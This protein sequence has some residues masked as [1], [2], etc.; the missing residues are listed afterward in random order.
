MGNTLR[1]LK[2]PFKHVYYWCVCK[3]INYKWKTKKY[4]PICRPQWTLKLIQCNLRWNWE[5]VYVTNFHRM[6]NEK[7]TRAHF[8]WLRFGDVWISQRNTQCFLNTCDPDV[9]E[10]ATSPVIWSL[11]LVNGQSDQLPGQV[12]NTWDAAYSEIF[13]P[14]S[15]PK[16]LPIRSTH[17]NTLIIRFKSTRFR[18]RS[19][20]LLLAHFLNHCL[21]SELTVHRTHWSPQFV[22]SE[23]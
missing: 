9:L 6:Q 11:S 17:W 20:V 12:G 5:E 2:W 22:V 21:Y 16:V 7:K 19:K 3:Y 1:S 23:N 8:P 14:G 10:K 18:V 15:H 13:S 4:Q